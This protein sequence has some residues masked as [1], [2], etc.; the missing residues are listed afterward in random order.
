MG[1]HGAPSAVITD[2]RAF[3]SSMKPL[4]KHGS[5]AACPLAG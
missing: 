1:H 3:F 4:G 2:F 5:E